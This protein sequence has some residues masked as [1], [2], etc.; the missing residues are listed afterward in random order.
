MEGRKVDK[1]VLQ[2][3]GIYPPIP[4]P[5]DNDGKV[6]PL[7][8][9]GN[10][11]QWNRFGLRGYV[12][13]G[14]NGE[15]VLLTEKEKLQS[16]ETARKAIPSDK[17]MIAGTGCEST[18][19]TIK[20]TKQSAEIGA[21]AA[22]IINPSYY[23]ARMTP[24][25]LVHHFRLVADASPIPTVIYNM[26]ACTGID[27]SAE[28]II[29]M[30]EHPNIIGV[31]DSSGNVIKLG[32]IHLLLGT[33]FQLLAGSAGFLLPALSVGAIGGVLA[34][35]NIAPAKC[36][37][38]YQHFLEGDWNKA[39]E[40]QVEVIPANTAVTRHWGVPA[41]KAAMDMLGFYGGPVRAP[42]LPLSSGEKE[43]LQAT[44]SRGG[45]LEAS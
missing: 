45:I 18:G 34:L 7:K 40:V 4:T 36:L 17:L 39:R 24:D 16:L 23:K 44:L 1:E 14:T 22:L 15:F 28:T 37:A 19:E 3:N 33:G 41:L 43:E 8:L 11:E 26:P 13:L 42:L 29:K 30:A 9:T 20:L 31:K 35:A 25:A 5:F 12:V 21:D 38:I 2:L 27:M 10:I 6:D 32:Q